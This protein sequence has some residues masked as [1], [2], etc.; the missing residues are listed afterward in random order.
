MLRDFYP[1]GGGGGG[2]PG[3]GGGGGDAPPNS[4]KS[5][6]H[7]ALGSAYM[8]EPL[9]LHNAIGVEYLS[10]GVLKKA[11]LRLV[12]DG[13]GSGR[14]GVALTAGALMSPKLLMVR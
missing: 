11:F 12:V 7:R 9:H 3:G 6:S 13:V 2:G 5:S 14:G 10:N 8:E 4:S 1:G